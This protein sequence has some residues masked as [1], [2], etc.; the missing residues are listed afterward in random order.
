[1]LQT[2]FTSAWR[3]GND[4]PVGA[5]EYDQI[6]RHAVGVAV[7]DVAGAAAVGVFVAPAAAVGIS[8]PRCHLV[9]VAVGTRVG[10]QQILPP[11]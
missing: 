2:E 6:G 4:G 5:E 1:M 11:S 3:V 10:V 7:P 9:G 8:V